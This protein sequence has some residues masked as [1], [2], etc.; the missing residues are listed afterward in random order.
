MRSAVTVAGLQAWQRVAH[1][2]HGSPFVRWAVHGTFQVCLGTQP[3]Y[4]AI[5]SGS[6]PTSA[7]VR[8]RPGSCRSS[9]HIWHIRAAWCGHTVAVNKVTYTH[10]RPED[11]AIAAAAL[12]KI[13]NAM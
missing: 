11:M 3:R 7:C 9:A 8:G 13:H 5:G 10:A 1:A 2:E 12:G 6:V 4:K